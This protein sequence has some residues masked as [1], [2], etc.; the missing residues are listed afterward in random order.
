MY[1]A[2]GKYITGRYFAVHFRD[3]ENTWP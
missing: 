2:Q 3:Q 1:P